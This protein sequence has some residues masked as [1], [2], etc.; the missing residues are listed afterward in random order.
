V[1]N[2]FRP[3]ALPRGTVFRRIEKFYVHQ[4]LYGEGAR[5]SFPWLR[6]TA[7]YPY[8]PATIAVIEKGL[9]QRTGAIAALIASAKQKASRRWAQRREAWQTTFNSTIA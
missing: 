1:L 9:L 2:G 4:L 3:F 8:F 7:I 6:P 5:S